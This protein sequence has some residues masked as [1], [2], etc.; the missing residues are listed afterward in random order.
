MNKLLLAGLVALPCLALEPQRAAA[1]CANLAGSFHIKFC[2]TGTLK[3]WAEKFPSCYGPK[4]GYG[5]QGHGGGYGAYGY[6]GGDPSVLTGCADCPTG[7]QVPGPW[8]LYWPYANTAY[9]TA[10]P[11]SFPG[12]NYG[13]HFNTPAPTGYPYWPTLT[14]APPATLDQTAHMPAPSVYQPVGYPSYWYG[15]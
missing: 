10:P 6:A 3:A 9:Q 15:H 1:Q 2:A 12:W 13:M 14:T 4:C 8:Y 11:M 5:G 7:L